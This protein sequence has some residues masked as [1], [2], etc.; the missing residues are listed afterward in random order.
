MQPLSRLLGSTCGS[1]P[2]R[3]PPRV[4]QHARVRLRVSA[5]QRGAEH[6]RRRPRRR[7]RGN[8]GG[9]GR[10]RTLVRR[11]GRRGSGGARRPALEVRALREG[12]R[13]AMGQRRRRRRETCAD[14]GRTRT[15]GGA[16][17][18]TR[19][20]RDRAD[21]SQEVLQRRAL[22]RDSPCILL[23]SEG[24]R[25]SGSVSSGCEFLREVERAGTHLRRGLERLVVRVEVLVELQDGRHVAA[26]VG[27]GT[28]QLPVL[29]SSTCA[30]RAAIRVTHR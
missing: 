23:R 8:T 5:V 20:R 27:P 12:W 25:R 18:S 6:T 7:L 22:C 1:T 4:T 29:A 3:P 19:L 28:G 10:K 30:R 16:G 26:P 2:T 15:A 24:P 9:R 17:A 11:D 14:A 21:A 13:R